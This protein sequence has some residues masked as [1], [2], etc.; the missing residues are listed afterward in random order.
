[1]TVTENWVLTKLRRGESTVGSWLSVGSPYLAQVMA[2][3]GFDWLVVDTEHGTVSYPDMVLSIQVLLP[4]PAVPIVRVPANDPVWIKR[5][6]D[7]GALGVLVPMVMNR[8]EAQRAASWARFPP[9]GSRSAGG[10]LAGLWHGDDYF[11]ASA[12][13]TLVAV[14]I[15]HEEAVAKADEIASVDGVDVVFIGPNDLAASM[16]LLGTNFRDNVRWKDA[17][18]RVLEVSHSHGKACGIQ[19]SDFE[20]AFQRLEQ[21]FRFVAVSSDARLLY[22]LVRPLAL[23][24]KEKALSVRKPSASS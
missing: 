23:R 17:V 10:W 12:S 22:S 2:R 16:S 7:V 11:T 15:E 1:M 5:A 21:G 9:V 4:G 14:Q 13:Q 24:L 8:E 20:E 18:Q 6:L 19:C 3:C